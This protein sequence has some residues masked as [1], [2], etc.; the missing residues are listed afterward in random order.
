MCENA[1]E[2][3]NHSRWVKGFATVGHWIAKTWWVCLRPI[4]SPVVS[5]KAAL[6]IENIP[7]RITLTLLSL[8]LSLLTMIIVMAIVPKAAFDT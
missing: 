2:N 4:T 1:I 6:E 8:A 7:L 3:P 5:A